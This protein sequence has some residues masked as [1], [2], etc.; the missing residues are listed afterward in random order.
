MVAIVV[1]GGAINPLN[2]KFNK[3]INSAITYGLDLLKKS[4]SAVNTVCET[5]KTMEDNPIFNAGTGAWLNADGEVEM[6]AILVDGYTGKVGAVAAIK[7]VRNPILVAKKVMEETDHILLVGEGATK[8]ARLVGFDEY[9]IVNEERRKKWN[10]LKN[11][12]LKG[13]DDPLLTYWTKIKKFV[14]FA[15]TVGAVAVDSDGRIAAGTSSG[16]FPM[17]LPGRVGDVPIVNAS[18][19]ASKICGISL[20]GY[21]ELILRTML[22]SK[23]GNEIENGET[24]TNALYKIIKKYGTSESGGKILLGGIALDWRGNVGCVKNTEYLPHGYGKFSNGKE[25]IR[26]NFGVVI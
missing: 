2:E 15:E 17:K 3:A 14:Q 24:P 9:N 6:D 11:K 4:E 7:K 18:T 13:E 10:E 1:H 5:I 20:S 16:G 8:F 23:I 22:A 19:Y 26:L 25:E 21:G 12:L